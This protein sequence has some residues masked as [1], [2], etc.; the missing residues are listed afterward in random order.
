MPQLPRPSLY[1]PHVYKSL[2]R[3]QTRLNLFRAQ[4]PD[5][6]YQLVRFVCTT[7]KCPD[8]ITRTTYQ[9]DLETYD[10]NMMRKH[11]YRW[12][13]LRRNRV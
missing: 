5:R 1:M 4:D 9:P 2:D 7:T 10:A 8:N 13:I 6:I 3:V 12:R 11:L